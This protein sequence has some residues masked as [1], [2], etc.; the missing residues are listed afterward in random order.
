MEDTGTLQS[1]WLL[2]KA[3]KV[4]LNRVMVL[5]TAS[6]FD[7]PPPGITPAENLARL[8]LGSYSSYLPALEAAWRVGNIVVEN[9]LLNWDR[10]R[11]VVPGE[12]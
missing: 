4:D 6:N 11:E 8:K 3:G 10:V 5:R 2:A 7:M 12:R 1:L 9:V